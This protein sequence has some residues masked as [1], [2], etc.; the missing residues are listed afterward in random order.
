MNTVEWIA[1]SDLLFHQIF[2]IFMG[3][4]YALAYIAG[5]TYQTIN[6][7]CYF[8]FYPATFALFLKSKYKYWVLP[9]TLLFFIIPNIEQKSNDFFN[10]CVLFLNYTGE[11]FHFN[12]ID[13]SVYFCVILPLVLYVPFVIKKF[14]IK[15]LK[16]IAFVIFLISFFYMIL[17][18]PFFKTGLI[19]LNSFIK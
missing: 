9:A 5:V 13:M 3:G 6:I 12:Y 11:L 1:H 17:I 19:Y 8:V 7:Y 10:K 15:T 2:L 16:I 4:L 14:E 18:Y